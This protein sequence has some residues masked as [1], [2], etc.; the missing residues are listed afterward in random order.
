MVLPL[1]LILSRYCGFLPDLTLA[2]HDN[3]SLVAMNH[4][5]CEIYHP[6]V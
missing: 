5:S 2:F 4:F 6:I 1:S 3:I